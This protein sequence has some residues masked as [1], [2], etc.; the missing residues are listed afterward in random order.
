MRPAQKCESP[1]FQ[2]TC[3]RAFEPTYF[4]LRS[5]CQTPSSVTN[6]DIQDE[7][8]NSNGWFRVLLFH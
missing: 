6:Q 2:K 1:G 4:H 7:K 8:Q 3:D 5:V